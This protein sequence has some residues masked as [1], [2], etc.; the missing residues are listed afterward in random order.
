MA[1]EIDIIKHYRYDPGMDRSFWIGEVGGS[2]RVDMF[3]G[4]SGEQLAGSMMSYAEYEAYREAIPRA[5]L[6]VFRI[7]EVE[8][9]APPGNT[10]GY[11]VGPTAASAVPAEKANPPIEAETSEEEGFWAQ[12]SDWAHGALDVAGFIPGLGAIP[13]LL[14]AGIYAVEGNYAAAAISAVAAVPIVGDAAKGVSMASKAAA[15][16]SAHTAKEAAEKTAEVAA[17][18]AAEKA[19]KEK[20]E[21]Q[22][23]ERAAGGR[24]GGRSKGKTK[25]DCRLRPYSQGCAG[26]KTPHHV[27]PD[28]VFK[29]P[30]QVRYA[31]GLSHAQGLCI[32]VDGGTPVRK[33]PKPNE[34]GLIHGMYD[35]AE[36]ALGSKGNPVGTALLAEIEALGVAS[37]SA[38]TGCNPVT[39]AAQ[40]RAYHQSKGLSPGSRFRADP[41]GAKVRNADPSQ[42]GQGSSQTGSGG[43]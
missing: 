10:I 37:A 15:K 11:V 23:A 31:G 27:V 34:H 41:R 14:N 42:L 19:A 3:R 8:I 38:I 43:L 28:R 35:A 40:V 26:G 39:M 17:K 32:C 33:G 36:A 9:E 30:S 6:P 29:N 7:P 25:R 4:A 12:A 2:V 21:K 16:I 13:D 20:A 5:R 22:A 24:D 18:K 1:L